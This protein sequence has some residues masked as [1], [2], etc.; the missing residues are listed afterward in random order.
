MPFQAHK[1]TLSLTY[2]FRYEYNEQTIEEDITYRPA[3]ITKEPPVYKDEQGNERPETVAEWLDRVAPGSFQGADGG[4]IS[5]VEFLEQH[6]DNLFLLREIEASIRQEA[7]PF[8]RRRAW[9]AT[10]NG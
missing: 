10:R 2:T 4:I 9:T 3:E 8:L 7:N 1:G 5:A 6:P